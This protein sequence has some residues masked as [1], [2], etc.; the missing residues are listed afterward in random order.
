MSVL[1]RFVAKIRFDEDGCWHWTS[2]KTKKGYADFWHNRRVA[3]HRLSYQWF[4]GPIPEGLVLDHLCRNRACVN[5][6]HLEPVT[7]GENTRRGITGLHHKIKTHCPHGH[8]YDEANTYAYR[9]ERG[10]RAC[11]TEAARAYQRRM[12]ST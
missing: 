4:V 2:A 7:P 5:P 6:D 11:R 12:A 10:C 1:D 8:P 9:G 3:A